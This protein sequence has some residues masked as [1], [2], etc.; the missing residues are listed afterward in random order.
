M[1][2]I[3]EVFGLPFANMNLQQSIDRCEEII[4]D[5]TP[6]HMLTANVD[7]LH[8]CSRNPETR[9]VVLG[10]DEVLCDG[11]PLV[12]ASKLFGGTSL[13]ERVAGS[14]LVPELLERCAENGHSVFFFGSD[15]DTLRHLQ[16]RLANELPD[17]E[18]AGA[19]S[20]PYGPMEEWNQGSIVKEIKNAAPDVLLVALGFP[21]QDEWIRMFR[22]VVDVPLSIG[23]GA[24]LDFLAGK[25]QRSPRWMQNSGL[26]WLWRLA[27]DP[28][29]L[30]WRYTKDFFSLTTAVGRQVAWEIYRRIPV[31]R[32]RK[33]ERSALLCDLKLDEVELTA[34]T[35]DGNCKVTGN[36]NGRSLICDLS[37]IETGGHEETAAMLSLCRRAIRER[38]PL[39]FFNPSK[40]M[41]FWLNCFGVA[42]LFPVFDSPLALK[43]VVGKGNLL[44]PIPGDI[45][46]P[47]SNLFA[48]TVREV[49]AAYPF[50]GPRTI[51]AD[52]SG[53]D[54]LSRASAGWIAEL[55]DQ[56]RACGSSLVLIGASAAN[57]DLLS[58]F[59]FG[60]VLE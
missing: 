1:N 16:D 34:F 50:V 45:E 37:S 35:T 15:S 18:I 36:Q 24:S 31:L 5:G 57:L 28:H 30:A 32:A 6:R 20:P 14:D 43:A 12:W 17:L 8:H 40:R 26:E 27:K 19:M 2:S 11:M 10:G 52:V 4:E 33:Q 55:H 44:L 3:S 25:Q 53:L 47:Q 56:L 9:W 22:D 13:P 51:V 60:R 59:G 49:A 58:I 23:V 38:K 42:D 46:G 54:R 39:A 7:F 21:K 48:N 29:R 41:Q